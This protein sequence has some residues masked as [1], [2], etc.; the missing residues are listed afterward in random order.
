MSS[1]SKTK[2]AAAAHARHSRQ[3]AIAVKLNQQHQHQAGLTSDDVSHGD[4]DRVLVH[5]P[6][7]PPR[8]LNKKEALQRIGGFSYMTVWQWMRDGK[9][10]RSFL[11]GGRVF[12]LESE[13]NDWIAAQ[14]RQ[15]LKGDVAAA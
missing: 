14:P 4:H 10:P 9:F 3:P 1:G 5:G 7:G 11:I 12:F 6:R 13:I 8:Y 15:R 2:S